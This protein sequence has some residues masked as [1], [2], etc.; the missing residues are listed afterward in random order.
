[1][2][3][4]GTW[5][6]PGQAGGLVCASPWLQP[7]PA[8]IV[9]G[10]NRTLS[11]SHCPLP[12]QLC[13]PGPGEGCWETRERQRPIET[14]KLRDTET[15]AQRK[16]FCEK[17]TLKSIVKSLG[18]GLCGNLGRMGSWQPCLLWGTAGVYSP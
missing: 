14:E 10:E 18:G 15:E 5:G 9:L 8:L 7:F 6:R 17:D 11:C 2:G 12:P 4:G 16:G 1:M 13:S 3:Q